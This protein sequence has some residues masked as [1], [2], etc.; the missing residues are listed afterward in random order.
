MRRVL[1]DTNAYVAFKRGQPEALRILQNTPGIAVNSVVLGELLSGFAV[2]TRAEANRR[3]LE[4]F[5]NS[6]RVEVFAVTHR[7]AEHYAAIFLALKG[8]GTPIPTND[9]WIAASAMEHDLGL[10]TYDAH[11][12]SIHGLRIGMSHSEL[13]VEG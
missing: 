6:P 1:I 8:A 9:M 7:T 4:E 10:F 3:E 5:L 12:R 13:E 11:F 2:G